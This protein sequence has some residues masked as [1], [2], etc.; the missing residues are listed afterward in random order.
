MAVTRN[1]NNRLL[2]IPGTELLTDEVGFVTL[3]TLEEKY[4]ALREREHRQL[5]SKAIAEYSG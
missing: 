3:R 2:R 5:R 1:G 4:A